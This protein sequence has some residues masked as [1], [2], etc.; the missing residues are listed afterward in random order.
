[1]PL[2]RPAAVAADPEPPPP[3]AATVGAAV[4]S[5]VAGRRAEREEHRRQRRAAKAA[6]RLMCRH[7]PPNATGG[8][9]GTLAYWECRAAGFD[10]LDKRWR[11]PAPPL[12][13]FYDP[14]DCR[15]T[16]GQPVPPSRVLLAPT[17]SPVWRWWT[18]L[19][20]SEKIDVHATLAAGM[21][22]EGDE[23]VPFV[24]PV[25]GTAADPDDAKSRDAFDNWGR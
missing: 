10:C 19:S 8:I 7:A 4:A 22:G 1:M 14:D 15:D 20:D 17:D 6:V 18:G 23:V 9:Q 12:T 24:A 16:S 11:R 21:G 2:T 25:K 13:P 5:A 3:G